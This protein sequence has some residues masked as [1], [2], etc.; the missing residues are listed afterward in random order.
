[1]MRSLSSAVAGLRSHQT[2]MDVI[3]NNIANVNTYG[4]K[5]SRTTFSDVF[6][7]TLTRGSGPTGL[8]GGTN[9]TQ[10]GYGASVATIDL[11]MT[12]SGMA[13]TGRALDVYINGDGMIPVRDANG[14]RFFTRLGV[15]GFDAA[16]N[17]VDSSGNF[18]EGFPMDPRTGRPVINPDGSVNHEDLRPIQVDPE[19]LDLMVGISIAPN[20][21]IVGMLPGDPD[22]SLSA[23]SPAW[24]VNVTVPAD[25]ELV[26]PISV[27]VNLERSARVMPTMDRPAS[28]SSWV[29]DIRAADG[30]FGEDGLPMEFNFMFDG[31]TQRII[32]E[33]PAGFTYSGAYRRGTTIE[34]RRD[35]GQPEVG[36]LGFFVDT[37]FTLQP[38][39]GSGE[40]SL[41][42][43]TFEN[44]PA[45]TVTGRDGGGNIV[46]DYW[47]MSLQEFEDLAFDDENYD[48]DFQLGRPG[49]DD[50]HQVTI[51]INPA[52]DP[53][54]A[55]PA[56]F[57][58][59]NF[60]PDPAQGWLNNV[61]LVDRS[62]MRFMDSPES[63]ISIRVERTG[64][65]VDGLSTTH[66]SF[67]NVLNP[68]ALTAV[69]NAHAPNQ[70]GPTRAFVQPVPPTAPATD[71]TGQYVM[72]FIQQVEVGGEMVWPTIDAYGAV[73]PPAGLLATPISNPFT[74]NAPA[75]QLAYTGAGVPNPES[76]HITFGTGAAIITATTSIVR[77]TT[78]SGIMTARV[79]FTLNPVATVRVFDGTDEIGYT[80]WNGGSR[81]T[82][83]VGDGSNAILNVNQRD[84]RAALAGLATGVTTIPAAATGGFLVGETVPQ[85][86]S[87][88]PFSGNVAN[89]QSGISE[90]FTIGLM[91]LARVPNVFAMEQMGTS[92]FNVT[93]N[94]GE[95]TFFRPGAGQTGTLRSGFLEMSNVDVANEFTDMIVTQ[96]GFQA[97]T[98][99]ITVSDEMLVEL[100]NLRR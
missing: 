60:V 16:G 99:I 8:T 25:T 95:A 75:A 49:S 61:T 81:I 24:L 55:N 6:Y 71:P 90:A 63:D 33:C 39:R 97:N 79:P 67:S 27:D 58:E 29:R 10:I 18:V 92:Y 89:V 78:P 4:F 48:R 34:L 35:P 83:P 36:K 84:L 74:P 38:A 31:I 54:L 13:S 66:F 46:S 57:R 68:A 20:G 87:N 2:R 59:L 37:D 53:S 47:E 73:T 26:G 5:S 30:M 56:R 96:R 52:E 3:G 41:G 32:A 14:N 15:L 17:L 91:A 100:V 77:D 11:M 82:V 80:E 19:L 65:Q 69:F 51:T 9:P 22:I 70:F 23:A 45:I 72:R 43:I 76:G 28:P 94:S 7:Q 44:R 42:R 1:M 62:E 85:E 21:E 50:F 64:N 88:W 93:P 40:E 86:I 98:R 12:Q